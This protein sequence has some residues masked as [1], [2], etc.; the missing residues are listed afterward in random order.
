MIVGIVV[1]VV[2]V[3]AGVAGFI[4]YK[5]SSAFS[6]S[7]FLFFISSLFVSNYPFV[8]LFYCYLNRRRQ[9]ERR[10]S[11]SNSAVLEKHPPTLLKQWSLLLIT[12]SKS[13]FNSFF[14][15]CFKVTSSKINCT[16]E[17]EFF[18]QCEIEEKERL[19]VLYVDAGWLINCYKILKK[20]H[21]FILC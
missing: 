15:F 10:R 3:A 13:I 12:L 5:Y 7:L 16:T 20:T 11:E 2:F 21:C 9:R 6:F 4:F 14:S 19:L 8:A 17:G 1:G 18:C